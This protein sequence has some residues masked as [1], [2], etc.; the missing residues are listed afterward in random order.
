MTLPTD[1]DIFSPRF[2]EKTVA[3]DAFGQGQSGGHQESRPVRPYEKRTISL[4][5]MCTS[6]GQ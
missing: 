2:E 6:A 1:F 4:P 3:I 5:M